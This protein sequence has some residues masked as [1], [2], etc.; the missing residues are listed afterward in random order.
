MVEPPSRMLLV[1]HGQ[2]AWSREGRHTGRTDVPLVDEGERQAT[3]LG[4]LLAGVAPERVWCSPR[5]RA[6][7]T[8]RLA[9][10]GERAEVVDDLAEWDY[11]EL[12]GDT[13]AGILARRPGWTLWSDGAPGGES[14][15]E[16]GRRADR[17]IERARSE[18]GTTLCFSHGH[19]LRVLGSRWVGLPPAG[20]RL[21]A[22]GPGSLSELG[23][24]HG[25]PVV[26]RWNRAP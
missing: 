24:E 5:R 26:V 8:C 23:W 6:L 3:S 12:E 10:F 1:R 18:G 16:V 22:L 4:A 14:P 2:T 11:G 9:G 15:A 17:L 19:L 7:E 25:A 21:L 20:G 13:T